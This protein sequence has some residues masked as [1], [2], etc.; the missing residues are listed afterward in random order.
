MQV[1]KDLLRDTRFRF[2]FI[3]FL[4]LAGLSVLSFFSPYNPYLWNQVPRDLPPQWPHILGTNSMGQDIFWKLTFAVRNSLIMSL[5][6]GLVSRVIAM[7][8]GMIAGYKGGAADRVLMF[9]SDSFLVIPLFIIIVL[10][11]TMVKARLSLPMLGLLLGV[12]GWAWDARVIR[13]QVLSLRERDFTYTALLSGSKAL[14]IVFKEYLPFLIPLIFA[15]LIG[16]MS[17]AIGMEITLAILGVS[18]LDI[19]TLGTMLQWSINYQALLLG[20]WWWVLTPVLTS[21]FLFIALYLI[22]IS[23]S[24]Y[25]DPRMRI[26]RIGQA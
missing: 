18:N 16:N 25:L 12:F 5:I 2:G 13:S 4:V 6:A 23:I 1:L 8:V 10:I 9:L 14:S 17:W 11:A 26:Q 22:S 7:I 15:T 24:E 19:P 21:I 3:V 20:Y